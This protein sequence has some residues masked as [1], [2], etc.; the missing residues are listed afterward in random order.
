MVKNFGAVSRRLGQSGAPTSTSH[1]F[2][3]MGGIDAK[4]ELNVGH[5][6]H[7]SLVLWIQLKELLGELE[8]GSVCPLPS[9]TQV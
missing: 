6:L 8:R 1:L 2:L 5:Y 7:A 4:D 3:Q 9:L